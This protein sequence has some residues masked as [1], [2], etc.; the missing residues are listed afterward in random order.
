MLINKIVPLSIFLC[1]SLEHDRIFI[2]VCL[3]WMRS[4]QY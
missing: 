1:L 3:G 2:G 4:E